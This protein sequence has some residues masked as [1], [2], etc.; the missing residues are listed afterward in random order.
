MR[1][2]SLLDYKLNKNLMNK[3]NLSLILIVLGFSLSACAEA[4][5]TPTKEVKTTKTTATTPSKEV[6]SSIS[7]DSAKT[8][9]NESTGSISIQPKTTEAV[10]SEQTSISASNSKDSTPSIDLSKPQK[11]QEEPNKVDPIVASGDYTKCKELT[12]PDQLAMCETNILAN[13]AVTLD[14]PSWCDKATLADAKTSCLTSYNKKFIKEVPSK[15]GEIMAGGDYTKCKDLSDSRE[16]MIC[17]T[18]LLTSKALESKDQS[19]CDK[20]TVEG[21]KNSCLY[22]FNKK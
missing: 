22:S 10:K 6:S 5:T 19:W 21:A 15:L 18:N 8:N 3:T 11:P 1:S 12:A 13:K 14:D 20:A 4:P 9:S 17:E 7:I 2:V 16:I